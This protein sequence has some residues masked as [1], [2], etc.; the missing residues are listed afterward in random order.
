MGG[1]DDRFREPLGQSVQNIDQL[2]E[3]ALRIE[4]F[5][6]VRADHEIATGRQAKL[7]ADI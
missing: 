5:F 4:V 2:R 3:I 1:D 7:V 6:A